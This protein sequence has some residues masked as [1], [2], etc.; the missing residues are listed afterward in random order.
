MN[1]PEW[2]S[3]ARELHSAAA[4]LFVVRLAR[5][6]LQV[7]AQPEIFWPQRLFAVH[8]A[9]Q[10]LPTPTPIPRDRP[11]RHPDTRSLLLPLYSGLSNYSTRVSLYFARSGTPILQK[12]YTRQVD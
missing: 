3:S 11:A 9:G 5:G 4:E 10:P 7:V 12:R 2:T 1:S 6:A 8:R